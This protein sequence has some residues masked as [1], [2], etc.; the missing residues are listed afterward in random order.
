[1]KTGKVPETILKRAVFKQLKV[2]RQ[3][4]LIGPS[5]GE[6]CSIGQF[7]PDE[8]FALSCDP[9]TGAVKDIGSLA[10]HITANDLAAAGAEPVGLMLTILLPEDFF[11]SDLKSIMKDVSATCEQLNLQVMGGHTEVTAA[12][13]QPILSVTGI[14][15][16]KKDKLL[17]PKNVKVGQDVIMTKWAGVEGTAI[18]ATHK[19]EELKLHYNSD[20]IEKAKAF[21]QYI[22]VVPES[23]IALA[24]GVTIMH[25]ATEGGIFGAVWELAASAHK[26]VEVFLDKIPIK[27]ET[28]EICE[29]FELNPYKLISSG[30]MLM[31]ADNGHILA[32][33]LISSGI[34][35]TVIGKITGG[36]DRIVIQDET[37]RSLEPA[38]SDEL[39]KVI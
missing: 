32:E 26:G 8:L 25:D 14:G 39:Y 35:A 5:I 38:K 10:V 30:T 34:Q 36:N 4:I 1:M 19:E 21:N 17:T 18:I 29:Y 7:G 27:Q 23:K 15:K 33:R 16:L 20:F 12:V 3:E 28:V 11:E 6:D 22:S 9:I 13:N 37:R 24:Y 31:V 2:K